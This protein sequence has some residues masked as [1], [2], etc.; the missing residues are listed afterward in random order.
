[1]TFSAGLHLTVPRSVYLSLLLSFPF[2]LR[3]V[4][5]QISFYKQYP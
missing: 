2:Y 4:S 1:M 5:M 3:S